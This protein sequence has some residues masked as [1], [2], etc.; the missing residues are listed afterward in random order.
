MVMIYPDLN[1]DYIWVVRLVMIFIFKIF[2]FPLCLSAFFLSYHIGYFLCLKLKE[3][4]EDILV[5]ENKNIK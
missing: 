4:S 1:R 5:K 3:S 2:I